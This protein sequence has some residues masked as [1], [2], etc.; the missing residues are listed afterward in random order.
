MNAL[1]IGKEILFSVSLINDNDTGGPTKIV[2]NS[3]NI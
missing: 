2:E 1:L 3:E